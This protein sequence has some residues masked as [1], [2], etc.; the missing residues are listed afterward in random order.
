MKKENV[1]NKIIPSIK[2]TTLGSNDIYAINQLQGVYTTSID[3]YPDLKS[4][5]DLFVSEFSIITG[6]Q[7]YLTNTPPVEPDKYIN[8]IVSGAVNDAF[9]DEYS[10]SVG[11]E[12]I[13]VK[14]PT[15]SGFFYATRTL[16]QLSQRND[17]I[18]YGEIHDYSQVKERGLM[19][20]VARKHF[21]MP[22][23]KK[24]IDQMAGIKMNVLQLHLSDNQGFRMETSIDEEKYGVSFETPQVLTKNNISELL[25]YA[26]ERHIDIIPDFDSPGH[27]DHIISVLKQSDPEKYA[28]ISEGLNNN[29]NVNDPIAVQ[30]TSDIINEWMS[31]FNGCRDFHI[32][33]DEYFVTIQNLFHH[34]DAMIYLNNLAVQVVSRGMQARI[35]N[36]EVYRTG[37]TIQPDKSTVISYWSSLIGINNIKLDAY[38]PVAELISNGYNVLNVN[39]NYLYY[40]PG[41]ATYKP[42]P[43][44][45]Y[46]DWT[47][48]VFAGDTT[49]FNDQQI[50][51]NLSHVL[52]STYCIWC[53]NGDDLDENDIYD[54]SKLALRAMAEKSWGKGSDASDYAEFEY[55]SNTWEPVNINI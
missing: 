21:S 39:Q 31:T 8:V 18:N 11:L 23:L 6:I 28:N 50:V 19:L 47:P 25:Q 45:I 40:S 46:N 35:W 44:E 55:L 29:L 48:M 36:D 10:L 53:D 12:G 22:W 43:E 20:D 9:N 17:E 13:S 2:K 37:G 34:D 38:A 32:G 16:L 14:A 33:G 51:E 5:L 41:N 27:M 7:L 4:V 49:S 26:S 15:T 42:K 1:M 3:E 54:E 24:M 52:G 30:V